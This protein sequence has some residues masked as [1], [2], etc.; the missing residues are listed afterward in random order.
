MT[1]VAETAVHFYLSPHFDD[2]VFSCGGRI[3]TQG[4]AGEK[5]VVVTVFGGAPE[6]GAALSSYAQELQARWGEPV[7]GV[8]RRQVEDVRA[9]TLLGA[10]RTYWPYLD[11]IYRRTSRGDLPYVGEDA[12]WGKIDTSDADLIGELGRRIAALP[13]V[14]D[15][16]LCVP[17]GVGGHVDHRIVRQAAELSGHPL[18]YYEDF[19]YARD[20]LAVKAALAHAAWEPEVVELSDQALRA[21]IAAMACYGSQ[22]STFWAGHDHMAASVRASAEE[23]GRGAPAERYWRR[24]EHP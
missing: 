17:L 4:Q 23:T 14:S 21:K 22:L 11:C 19:P 10:M 6:A 13:L 1:P 16:R 15:G 7:E 20:G 3:W 9:I 8:R 18:T 12:L 5:V 24:A 2:A